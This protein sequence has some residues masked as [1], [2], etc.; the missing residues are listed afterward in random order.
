MKMKKK[1]YK[2]DLKSLGLVDK[3]TVTPLSGLGAKSS[4][5]YH[6]GKAVFICSVSRAAG[7]QNQAIL[8]YPKKGGTLRILF[9]IIFK[10][11][12]WSLMNQVG[13][14]LCMTNIYHTEKVIN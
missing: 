11:F 2:T 1:V 3:S 10:H 14:F 7:D 6:E 9:R 13:N 4:S 8:C 12:S 5:N